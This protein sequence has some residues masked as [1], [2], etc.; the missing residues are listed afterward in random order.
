MARSGGEEEMRG[1]KADASALS[2]ES[3]EAAATG[4]RCICGTGRQEVRRKEKRHRQQSG[5]KAYGGQTVL[6]SSHGHEEE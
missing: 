2:E 3:S 4:A 5:R 1:L 6:R